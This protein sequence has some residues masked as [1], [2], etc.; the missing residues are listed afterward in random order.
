MKIEIKKL[1]FSLLDDYLYFFEHVAHENDNPE[2][3]CYCV[4]WNS[5]DDA[6]KDFSTA[7]DRKK[8]AIDNVEKGKTQGYLAYIDNQVVGWCNANEKSKCLHCEG[9]QGCLTNVDV[10]SD[11]RIKSIFCFSIEPNMRNK[12]IATQLLN[13]VCE[14]AKRDGFTIVEAYPDKEYN[15]LFQDFMG[16]IG[17]YKKC[18]FEVY[19]ETDQKY[20]MRK[21][22]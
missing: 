12:G 2:N 16:P 4:G 20:I 6:G 17:L 9:W 22:L 19:E 11:V 13:Q 18:G 15:E 14:D 8:Y 7:K 3:S 21:T 10:S 5:S 1:K